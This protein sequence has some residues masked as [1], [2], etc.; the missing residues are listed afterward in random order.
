MDGI[1]D[2]LEAVVY[3][4]E[5]KIDDHSR[6]LKVRARAIN[7]GT[8]LRPGAYARVFYAPGDL[9]S[10]IFIPTEALIPVL[11]GYK[12]YLYKG[13]KAEEVVVETGIRNERESEIRSGLQAGDTL[14]ASGIMRLRPGISVNIDS[15][16]LYE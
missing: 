16:R 6:S 10:S 14:I 9:R 3:A 15:V 12:V 13:G 1:T 7:P 2:T 4:T 11:K 8:K 5:A